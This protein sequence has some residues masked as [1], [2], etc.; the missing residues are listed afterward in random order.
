MIKIEIEIR[1]VKASDNGKPV[2][3][4]KALHYNYPPV[5]PQEVWLRSIVFDMLEKLGKQLGEGEG[6]SALTARIPH[7]PNQRR[8]NDDRGD[9]R[10]NQRKMR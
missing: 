7:D 10:G 2:G 5:T 9:T 1:D 6:A 8:K 3:Q 4:M